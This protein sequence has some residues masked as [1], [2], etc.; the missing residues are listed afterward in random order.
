[1]G[2]LGSRVACVERNELRLLV[3]RDQSSL[4]I[5]QNH[6]CLMK[7]GRLEWSLFKRADVLRPRSR[8]FA[9]MCPFSFHFARV[10]VCMCVFVHVCVC[11]FMSFR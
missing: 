6:L 4:Q 2:K 1:M 9:P 10:C 5:V 11:A 7:G 3:E 8:E